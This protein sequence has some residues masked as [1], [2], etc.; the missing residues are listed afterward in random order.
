MLLPEKIIQHS[1]SK[2]QHA[3]LSNKQSLNQSRE[4]AKNSGREMAALHSNLQ[5]LGGAA[6]SPLS[7]RIPPNGQGPPETHGGRKVS[8]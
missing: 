3:L 1:P 7:L 4:T 6:K 5:W 2:E 8:H